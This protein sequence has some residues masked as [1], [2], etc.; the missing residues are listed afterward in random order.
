MFVA[1]GRAGQ[2]PGG[3][4]PSGTGGAG[5]VLEA[6]ARE[7]DDGAAGNGSPEGRAGVFGCCQ[8]RPM[9]RVSRCGQ[10]RWLQSSLRVSPAGARDRMGRVRVRQGRGQ[11]GSIKRAPAPPGDGGGADTEA[12][13]RLAAG[14]GKAVHAAC[15]A[16]G[17]LDRQRICPSRRP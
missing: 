16:S 8:V 10:C 15:W 4:R 11:A 9:F 5:G 1:S 7:P 17:V 3:A 13:S 6:A 2:G 12:T 14:Q